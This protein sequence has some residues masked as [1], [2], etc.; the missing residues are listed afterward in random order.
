MYFYSSFW[1]GRTFLLLPLKL[2]L[3]SG[4]TC[5]HYENNA[6]S[7]NRD[8][9]GLVVARSH[10]DEATSRVDSGE[11]FVP[12]TTIDNAISHNEEQFTGNGVDEMISSGA[13]GHSDSND[14]QA[15]GPRSLCHRITIVGVRV[16]G[17]ESF[18]PHRSHEQKRSRVR[19]PGFNPVVR[20]M[21]ICYASSGI[22]RCLVRALLR[23]PP[24]ERFVALTRH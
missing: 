15:E 3:S 5:V 7:E 8:V 1:P 10:D 16:G 11:F 4:V 2:S 21:A 20:R 24:L 13:D 22:L 9:M 19:A 18:D 6:V 12:R 14:N 17:D 23:L